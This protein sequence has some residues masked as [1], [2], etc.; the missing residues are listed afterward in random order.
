MRLHLFARN[1]SLQGR[2]RSILAI[3]YFLPMALSRK[4]LNF[5]SRDATVL[6][7]RGTGPLL[8]A[9]AVTKALR[10]TTFQ[11]SSLFGVQTWHLGNDDVIAFFL[12]HQLTDSYSHNSV[13]WY[14]EAT[15]EL[16]LNVA[17]PL[18]QGKVNQ[19][20]VTAEAES[21]YVNK[22]QA[23]CR[24]GVWGSACNTYYVTK[25]GW[26]HT[27]YPWSKYYIQFV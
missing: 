2:E 7:P 16:I 23:A 26:N 9:L 15:V 3:C 1:Q 21:E 25:N 5:H 27:M 8:V 4:L 13:I 10:C 6:H 14:I 12:K 18:I 19:V 11:T 24:R 22:V 20:E 17:T